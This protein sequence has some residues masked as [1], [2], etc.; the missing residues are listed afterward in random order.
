ME[1]CHLELIYLVKNV[2]FHSYVSLPDGNMNS[3]DIIQLIYVCFLGYPD[4]IAF[5][6]VIPMYPIHF[7]IFMLCILTKRPGLRGKSHMTGTIEWD[8][9]SE[10]S[11]E[12]REL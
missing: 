1:N 11:S 3:Y 5:I 12:R 2:I 9:K 6:M 8:V 4:E 10:H 7:P